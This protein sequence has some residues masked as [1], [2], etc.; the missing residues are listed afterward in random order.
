MKEGVAGSKGEEQRLW[1]NEGMQEKIVCVGG[2]EW[3]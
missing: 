3:F 1:A 2:A